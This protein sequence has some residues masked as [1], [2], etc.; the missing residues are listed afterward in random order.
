MRPFIRCLSP[1]VILSRAK[2]PRFLALLAMTVTSFL[3][4]ERAV[5]N[6]TLN[7]GYHN[8]LNATVGV[9]FMRLSGNWAFEIG[10]GWVDLNTID[11]DKDDQPNNNSNNNNANDEDEDTAQAAI[12]G[13]IDIKYL[14]SSG[15]FRPFL[16][17]GFGAGVAAE[18]G[19]H[20][21]AGAGI[22]GPFIGGGLFMGSPKFYGYVSTIFTEHFPIQAGIGFDM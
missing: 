14:F 18:V 22:G 3:V 19:K 6:W 9:N 20:I 5:A 11:T 4:S 12:A 13:E 17:G 16:Q 15:S 8:P 10:I 7:L 2:D 21:D 1:F